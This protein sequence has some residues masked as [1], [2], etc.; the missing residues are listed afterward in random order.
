MRMDANDRDNNFEKKIYG[1]AVWW[2]IAEAGGSH[3]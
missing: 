2:K 3:I 1:M